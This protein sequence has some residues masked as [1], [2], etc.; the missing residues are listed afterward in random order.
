MKKSLTM[1]AAALLSSSAMNAE[2]ATFDFTVDNPYGWDS[3]GK[4][5]DGY[6][7]ETHQL[8]EEVVS[9]SLGGKYRRLEQ[10][11][12]GGLTCLLLYQ[13][14]TADFAV[15]DGYKIRTVTFF[16]GKGKCAQLTA[17]TDG[18][19]L[20]AE[21]LTG[22]EYEH[23]TNAGTMLGQATRTG[24]C[25]EPSEAIGFIVGA[26]GTQVISKIEVDYLKDDEV[27]EPQ[28]YSAF[29]NFTLFGETAMIDFPDIKI[30]SWWTT[31]PDD[32]GVYPSGSEFRPL[33]ISSGNT[34]IT[35]SYD[36]TPGG[37]GNVRGTT[38]TKQNNLQLGK[39]TCLTVSTKT[40]DYQ[41]LKVDL[42][43]NRKTSSGCKLDV[44][45]T[46]DNGVLSYDAET[47]LLTWTPKEAGAACLL[48][49]DPDSGAYIESICAVYEKVKQQTGTADI[50]AAST[51]VYFS[52]QGIR[53]DKPGKGLYIRRQG[54][55]VEKV[56]IR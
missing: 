37:H 47:R 38:T 52:L 12:F 25:A 51:P 21:V 19:S 49:T 46:D 41:L 44:M 15:S 14:T 45:K 3:F 29:Y 34:E 32:E 33:T 42:Q 43:G 56:L 28:E 16:T 7:T 23:S 39:G 6:I 9:L 20:G 27:V 24:Q 54:S 5:A 2:V 13:N 11:A 8:D 10:K 36:G 35:F 22:V 30:G 4:D 40:C 17:A 26:K 18:A 1:V 31:N 48:N 53:T 55:K 50:E